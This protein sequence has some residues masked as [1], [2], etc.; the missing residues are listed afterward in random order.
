MALNFENA[1][2]LS[3][4]RDSKYLGGNFRYGFTKSLTIKGFLYESTNGSGVSGNLN[5]ISGILESGNNSY[6]DIILNG[7]NFGSGKITSFSFDEPNPVR[8]G[9]YTVSVEIPESGEISNLPDDS[10]YTGLSFLTETD[11]TKVEDITESFD[12]STAEDGKFTYKHDLSFKI[13]DPDTDGSI[14]LAKSLAQNFYNSE[15]SFGLLDNQYSG[16]YS[17]G[18]GA[19]YFSESYDLVNHE[20][21]FSKN[22]STNSNQF[23]SGANGAYNLNVAHQ[24]SIAEDGKIEIVENGIVKSLDL[25][26]A[27]ALSGAKYEIYN[28]SISR[29]SGVYTG[30]GYGSEYIFSTGSSSELGGLRNF[31]TNPINVSYDFDLSSNSVSYSA[32]FTNNE[33]Y[34]AS[35]EASNKFS[36]SESNGIVTTSQDISY[37]FNIL[38]GLT[39]G[40]FA[41]VKDKSLQLENSFSAATGLGTNFL[42]QRDFMSHKDFFVETSRSV[43]VKNSDKLSFNLSIQRENDQGLINLPS[44]FKR[45]NISHQDNYGVSVFTEKNFADENGNQF[46]Q[47]IPLTN[48]SSRDVSLTAIM[49]RQIQN[50]FDNLSTYINQ[51]NINY[52]E[53][54]G[55]DTIGK[56]F[57]D[58]S[59]YIFNGCYIDQIGYTFNKNFDLGYTMKAIY[60]TERSAADNSTL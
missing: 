10:Y 22:Y 54:S 39:S 51:I 25:N 36:I 9:S 14:A 6:Q 28:N 12:F 21:S 3:F 31:Y 23:I 44:G 16:Y 26:I 46:F 37:S 35:G 41:L 45:I 53:A 34:D 56:F 43:S 59:N 24:I 8:L 38:T 30:Y 60:L 5:T 32:S 7:V 29:V 40:A 11:L 57:V 52:C 1:S 20:F 48:E 18:S 2:L 47:D 50:P 17:L 55:I 27:N 42:Y 13:I 33:F 4:N 15:P 19:K 58:N 49:E